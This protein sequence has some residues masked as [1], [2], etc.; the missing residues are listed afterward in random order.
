MKILIVGDIYSKLGRKAFD[1]GLAKIKT[2]ETINFL[3]VNGEN[4]T[5]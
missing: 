4:I 5:H 1:S 2:K 3:I